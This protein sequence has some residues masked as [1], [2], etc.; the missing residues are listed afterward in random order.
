[1]EN[2]ITPEIDLFRKR[3]KI[4]GERTNIRPPKGARKFAI[5]RVSKLKTMGKITSA[6]KH[7]LRAMDVPNADPAQTPTNEVLVG[8]NDP[9]DVI[10]AWHDRAPDKVRSNAVRALEYVVTASPEALAEMGTQDAREYLVDALEWLKDRHG[11]EN[12]L[13]AVIHNDE[14]SP[15]LQAVVIPMDD[16]DRLNA[17]AFVNGSKMLSEMQTDFAEKVGTEHGLER[18]IERSKAHHTTI[19]EHYARINAVEEISVEAPE[20]LSGGFMGRGAETDEEWRQRASAALTEA[21]R[22]N[23]GAIT[24]NAAEAAQEA[25]EAI[26]ASDLGSGLLEDQKGAH[27]GVQAAV[28]LFTALND[29]EFLEGQDREQALDVISEVFNDVR[30]NLPQNA[31]EAIEGK[32]GDWEEELGRQLIQNPSVEHDLSL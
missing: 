27:R 18:G 28:E 31:R 30:S 3:G 12:V 22:A 7:N 4:E 6:A 17:R 20:R 23:V 26:E 21:L 13:S 14:T 15:H 2:S 8:G 10:S 25:R 11:T 5:L 24:Q 29:A 1:M 19:K 16:R 9:A 32:L